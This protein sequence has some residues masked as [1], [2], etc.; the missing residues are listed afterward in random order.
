MGR[1]PELDNFFVATG[2]LYGIAAGGGA[3]Q[4]DG[5]VDPRRP[6]VARPVAA[7]RAPVLVPPH[8][9]P[10]H[11]PADGRAV[12]PPLQARRRR[13][14]EHEHARGVR[15]SPLHDDAA[16]PPARCS[17]SRGGWERPNW[18]APDGRRGRRSAVVRPSRTGSTH[19]GAE[20][21]AVR[22]RRGAD[23]PDLVRQV[24]DHRPRR[25]RRRAV[26]V[27]RRTWTSRS[28]RSPT[29]SCATSVA[30]SSATSR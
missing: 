22:E 4:D 7:R 23:R 21:R 16:R 14:S 28:A 19:V 10:L 8:H 24:R 9:A 26:A 27:G 15:R 11:G 3:G 1:A 17:A 18:F 20:H 5:R 6:S 2:F 29:P 12:R 25:A 13:A 30:A